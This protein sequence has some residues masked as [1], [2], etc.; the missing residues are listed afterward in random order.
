MDLRDLVGKK[1]EDFLTMDPG[2][3]DFNR[4]V[5]DARERQVNVGFKLVREANVQERTIRDQTLRAIRIVAG[6]PELREEY[7]RASMPKLLPELRGRP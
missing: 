1:A 2:S 6:T 3:K 5:F 4:E 7:I